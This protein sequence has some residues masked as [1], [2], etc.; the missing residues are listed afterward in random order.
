MNEVV[1]APEV[2]VWL[3]VAKSILSALITILEEEAVTTS[4]TLP[5]LTKPAPAA[6]VAV[7]VN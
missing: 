3:T 2:F 6:N 7:P 4:S 1:F 5:V